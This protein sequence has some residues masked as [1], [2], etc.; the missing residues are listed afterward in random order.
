MRVSA[1]EFCRP[2]FHAVFERMRPTVG[3]FAGHDPTVRFTMI[4][5]TGG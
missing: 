4:G 1:M 3:G 5:G 2:F